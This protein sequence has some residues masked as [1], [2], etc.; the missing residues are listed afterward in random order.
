MENLEMGLSILA[1]VVSIIS[2][3][4]SASAFISVKKVTPKN[5][6]KNNELQNSSI[7]SINSGDHSNNNIGDNNSIGKG[8]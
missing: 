2:I 8:D 4:F 7:N 5:E 6:T 1:S 3:F